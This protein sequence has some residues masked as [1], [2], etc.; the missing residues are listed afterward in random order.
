MSYWWEA[1]FA[2]G[3][4]P[5]PDELTDSGLGN[6]FDDQLD[7]EQWLSDFYLDLLDLGVTQVSLFET[8]RLVYGPMPLTE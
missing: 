2:A 4:E 7:A 5:N 8:D 3:S 6:R 1:K